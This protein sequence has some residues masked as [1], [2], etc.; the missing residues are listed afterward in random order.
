M[1]TTEHHHEAVV[2]DS[3]AIVVS[4]VEPELV[5]GSEAFQQVAGPIQ[6]ALAAWAE[7]I[8]QPPSR[9][10]GL[11]AR[12]KYVT[13]GEVFGQ[14]ALAYDTADDDVVSGVLETSESVA[15][16]KVTFESED[17]DQENVWNQIGRDLNLDSFVRT[18]FRELNLVSQIYPVR[19][20]G[21]KRYTVSGK[22]DKGRSRRKEFNLTVPVGLGFLDP[23]R[24]VPVNGDIFG[25]SQLAWI[26]TDDELEMVNSGGGDREDQLISRLF[27]GQYNTSRSEEQKLEKEDIDVDRLVALNP[28][29]V[30]RHTLTKAPFDRWANVR[31]K[32]LFPLLD[33]KHQLREMD[34]AFLLGGINF[35]VLV[36]RGT[37]DRPTS[38][39]EV[40][41]T[42]TMLRTQSKTPVIVTDHRINIEIITPDVEHILNEA[43]WKVVDERILM[44]MWGTFQMPSDVGGRETSL[45]LGKVIARG[46]ASRRHMLKR[47]IEENLVRATQEHFANADAEFDEKVRLEFRPRHIELE[48]DNELAGML[49]ELRD[50]G[51]LSRETL[52]SEFGFDQELEALRRK[53]EDDKY[54]DTFPPVN[55]PFD[56]PNKTTPSG[57]G[58]KSSGGKPSDKKKSGEQKE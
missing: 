43:K 41:A 52:L 3:G 42:A 53:T 37:D 17:K 48:F 16:Q 18:A 19:W 2:T 45:T 27:V 15:F 57:S 34:R 51:D 10:K 23:T 14:M 6:R 1:T 38:T 26:A 7:D 35:V 13:P 58:R 36:T 40:D 30:Y 11:F 20:W 47:S 32:S 46:L 56:S 50:R 21:Q 55:V 25:G 44:K 33:I 31:M 9:N 22:G 29:F 28:D 12:N 54:P 8:R 49:Q 5:M 4:E 39:S 24:V